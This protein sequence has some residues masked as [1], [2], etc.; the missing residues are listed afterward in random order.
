MIILPS[1]YRVENVKRF[2]KCYKDTGATLQVFIVLDMNNADPY[3]EVQIPSTIRMV[4]VTTG[5][6]IGDI[7]NRIFQIYPKEDFY[8]IMADD[9]IPSTY[10]W[11]ILLKE[12][13]MPDKI[14]WGYDGGHDETLPRH[15]FIGG[16]LARKLGFLSVPGV[17]HWY[18][19]NGWRD[20][21]QGLDC[22]RYMPE[23]RMKHM[24]YIY[25]LAQKD[26]TYSDQPNVRADEATYN[27][28]KEKDLPG[29]LEKL[30]K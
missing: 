20:I 26:R 29:I 4:K 17:K 13:C 14:V 19:D 22:G 5:T 7:F 25:G 27:L 30:K 3:L 28:W 8:G 2:V 12:A 9:V 10:R 6:R 18:V 23:I 16:D 15:P 21:A 24:H 1:I 11:D